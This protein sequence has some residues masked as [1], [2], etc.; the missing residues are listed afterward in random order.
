MIC[1]LC[2]L[3]FEGQAEGVTTD[4]IIADLL[5]SVKQ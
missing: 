2:L 4:V 1:G 5:G 3:N